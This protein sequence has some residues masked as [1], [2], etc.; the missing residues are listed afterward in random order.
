MPSFFFNDQTPAQKARNAYLE[1]RYR[2][3]NMAM[4]KNVGQGLSALGD[5]IEYRYRQ[6][7]TF[8]EAP[9]PRSAVVNALI[10]EQPKTNAWSKALEGSP[11]TALFNLGKSKLGGGL[12]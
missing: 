6:N 7:N 5:G 8:P 12:Y 11:L 3:D 10:G 9:S 2:Y 1:S 4:P